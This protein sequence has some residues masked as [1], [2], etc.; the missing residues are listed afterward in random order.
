MK[1]G[2][3]T[4]GT[5]VIFFAFL[6]AISYFPAKYMVK[7]RILLA[8][9]FLIGQETPEKIELLKKIAT[10]ALNKNTIDI[11]LLKKENCT[12]STTVQFGEISMVE[13]E[14]ELVKIFV[15]ANGTEHVSHKAFSEKGGT[16]ITALYLVALLFIAFVF[17]ALFSTV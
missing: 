13:V 10:E 4:F 5:V 3:I 7:K 15:Y 14:N 8:K 2:L 9:K 17:C 11:K 12:V 1:N 6:Y 16:R